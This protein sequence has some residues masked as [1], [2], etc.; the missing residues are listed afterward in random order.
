MQAPAK[1][2]TTLLAEASAGDPEAYDRL[3]PLVYDELRRIAA[4]CL[5]RE[6]LDHTLQP[7]AL[8]NEAFLKL[9]DQRR[10]TWQNRAHFF[11][12][13]ARLMRRVLVDHARAHHAGKRGGHLARVSLDDA[14][15]GA[16]ARDADLVALDDALRE[17]ERRDPDAA[18]LVELRYFAGLTTRETAEVLGVSTS[19][20]EREWVAARAW[21][22][23]ALSPKEPGQ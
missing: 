12:V 14:V 5:R 11:A 13:S 1:D 3:A 15:I 2:V 22:F 6:R 20:V 10:V 19:T 18:R 16:R 4:R 7:T 23:R 9:I 21:L 8:V 17:L